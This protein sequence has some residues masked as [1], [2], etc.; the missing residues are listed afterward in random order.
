MLRTHL[1]F[2]SHVILSSNR[3][4]STLN[5]IWVYTDLHIC[6][7]S[8]FYCL[9]VLWRKQMYNQTTL[10]YYHTFIAQT[11]EWEKRGGMKQTK[12]LN[13]REIRRLSGP[14]CPSFASLWKFLRISQ[15]FW[16]QHSFCFLETHRCSPWYL[17]QIHKACL[18]QSFQF[19]HSYSEEPHLCRSPEIS[20]TAV[21]GED[22]TQSYCSDS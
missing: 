15:F 17:L 8:G 10:Q 22:P 18:H 14:S 5:N 21:A 13:L 11:P 4:N 9:S 2:I 16:R 7:C 1:D 6:D 12:Q 19:Q 20:R 3:S